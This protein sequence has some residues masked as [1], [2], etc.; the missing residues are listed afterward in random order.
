[1]SEF[2]EESFRSAEFDASIV[3]EQDE[4][5]SDHHTEFSTPS[6]KRNSNQEDSPQFPWTETP[7]GL[8]NLSKTDKIKALLLKDSR[9][10]EEAIFLYKHLKPFRFFKYFREKNPHLKTTDALVNLC[11][12]L[13]LERYPQDKLIYKKDDINDQKVYLVLSGH[14]RQMIEKPKDKED[15]K[16]GNYRPFERKASSTPDLDHLFNQAKIASINAISLNDLDNL[17]SLG[18]MKEKI[19]RRWDFFGHKC[20]QDPDIKREHTIITKTPCEFLTF[21]IRD[22]EYLQARYS[23]SN[24][25]LLN[26]LLDYI[27][28]LDQAVRF[29]FAKNIE[30]LFIESSYDIHNTIIEEGEKGKRLYLLDEGTCEVYK[31][32][33]DSKS[34]TLLCIIQPGMFIGE[35]ILFS[36]ERTY[37]YTVRVC[38]AKARVLSITASD[39][40]Y[41]LPQQILLEV[42]KLY[43][44][45]NQKNLNIHKQKAEQK[46]KIILPSLP[47]RSNSNDSQMNQSAANAPTISS[48]RE[49]HKTQKGR[50]SQSPELDKENVKSVLLRKYSRITVFPPASF[51]KET[52]RSTS[53][54]LNPLSSNTK[55]WE[56]RTTRYHP[57]KDL[58]QPE[59]FKFVFGRDYE[60]EYAQ[61]VERMLDK[62]KPIRPPPKKIEDSLFTERRLSKMTTYL[63]DTRRRQFEITQPLTSRNVK[64]S[65]LDPPDH[66]ED[67]SI[68]LTQVMKDPNNTSVNP[69]VTSLSQ[70]KLSVPLNLGFFPGMFPSSGAGDQDS[71]GDIS[72][73]SRSKLNMQEEKKVYFDTTTLRNRNVPKRQSR[74]LDKLLRKI[75][76]NK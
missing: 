59:Q 24:T 9:T 45:K 69:S 19:L 47:L 52:F 49:N 44:R 15:E 7:P 13:K 50:T 60:E 14:V 16:L 71:R 41:Q 5:Y 26:F 73:R 23:K 62:N 67:V 22:H 33:G 68:F 63:S 76:E 28:E 3:L 2:I 30:R 6:P 21:T 57:A 54:A 1:M 27:P 12:L 31:N 65:S 34:K 64:S 72:C 8:K 18:S 66:S 36:K 75:K 10:E 42:K 11:K 48:Y 43:L 55:D 29:G 39:F 20:L 53:P 40:Y 35:E 56:P 17:L 51:D 38:S 25:H 46:K 4:E 32:D 70:T 61:L 37:L 74:M 58:S